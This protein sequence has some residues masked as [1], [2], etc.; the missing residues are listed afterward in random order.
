MEME[1]LDK[2]IGADYLDTMQAA[3]AAEPQPL[4]IHLMEVIRVDLVE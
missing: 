1:S 3:E 4:E 2:E